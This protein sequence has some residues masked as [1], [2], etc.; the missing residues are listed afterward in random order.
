MKK[1]AVIGASAG[2]GLEIVRLLQSRRQFVRAISRHPPPKSEFVEPFAA[3]V[4]DVDSLCRALDGDFSAVFFT[5][6]IHNMFAS[7]QSVREVMYQGCLNVIDAINI[8]AGSKASSKRPKFILLS[9][10]GADKPSWVWWLLN[11]VKK[12]MKQN[13]LDREKALA[14]SG[15][16]YVILRAARLNDESGNVPRLAVSV[17]ARRL[18]MKLS[19]ARRDVA[20]A[21]IAAA[22]Y[23]PDGTIWDMFSGDAGPVPAWLQKPLESIA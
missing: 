10:I 20:I 18:E 19:I 16:G 23:A 2:T 6:D 9:V 13:I 8:V 14:E 17:A 15:L 22:D 1:Y 4:C 3:D 11:A 12:G 21:M 7:K 5:V